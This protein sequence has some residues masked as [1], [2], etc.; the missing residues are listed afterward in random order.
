M[1]VFL[2]LVNG[3]LTVMSR[4][5]NAALAVRVG[6]LRGAFVNHLVG[7]LCAGLLLLAGLRTGLLRFDGIPLVYFS[8]GCLGVLV[9]AASNY[10][11]QHAGVVVFSVLLLTFQLLASAAIDHWGLMGGQV[12]PL[13]VSR[14]C[15]LALVIVGALLVVSDRAQLRQTPPPA[16]G[17]DA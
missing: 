14:A 15:G 6:S 1:F 10:A 7:T 12:V 9:V 4:V 3:A 11:V 5:T 2:A 8:G 16:E 13:T 17:R